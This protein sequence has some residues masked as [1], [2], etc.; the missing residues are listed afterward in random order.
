M[1]SMLYLDESMGRI[2][3]KS[4]SSIVRVKPILI[5]GYGH[6]KNSREKHDAAASLFEGLRFSAAVSSSL[7]F[8]SMATQS[9]PTMKNFQN[10]ETLL[11]KCH[12]RITA[13][14]TVFYQNVIPDWDK[15]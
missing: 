3:G 9:C 13:M 14:Q 12:K 8:V 1:S 7:R 6:V 15:T 10:K 2:S 11:L 5:S 4:L